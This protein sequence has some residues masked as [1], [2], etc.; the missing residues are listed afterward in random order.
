MRPMVRSLAVLV[1]MLIATAAAGQQR[2]VFDIDDYVDPGQRAGHLFISRLI[3]GG[4]TNLVDGYRPLRDDVG[5]VHLA[6]SFYFSSFQVDYKHSELRTGGSSDLRLC[7]C[8]PPVY[9]P[10][11]PPDNALPDPPPAGS[12]DLLQ[13]AWYQHITDA[14]GLPLALRYRAS[15]GRDLFSRSIRSIIDG[16]VISHLSGHEQSFGVEADTYVS[17]RGHELLGSWAFRR[18]ARTGSPDGRSQHEIT[19]TNRFGQIVT[20]WVLIYPTLTV[21][22]VSD[23]GG[24]VLNVVNPQFDAVWHH[25]AT[26][27]NVHLVYSPHALNSGARGWQTT[28]QIALFVDRALLVKLFH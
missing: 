12:K 6:N 17:I 22:G 25:D 10:T 14:A 27:V 4:V 1:A 23:R 24:T 2:V 3:A 20:K 7:A 21:G 9:F 26:D 28:H 13:V 8:R 5:F 18:T 19:Y 16:K 11:P 15:F